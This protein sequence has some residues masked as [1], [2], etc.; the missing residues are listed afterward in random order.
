ML[1]EYGLPVGRVKSLFMFPLTFSE[2]LKALGK[3]GLAEFLNKFTLDS[4]TNFPEIIHQE[5]LS[6]L[7]L[8]F[9]LGGMPKVVS[10][11]IKTNDIT[12]AFEEQ[13]LILQGYKDDFRK[14][15]KKTDWVLLESIFTKMGQI[16]GG[17]HIKFSKIDPELKSLQIRRALTALEHAL[18]F[19][20]I[21]ATHCKKL[22][23]SAHAEEKRFKI[24]FLDI[25]LL[26]HLL[27]FDWKQIS[28]DSDLTNIADGRFAEQFVAQ[29]IVATKSNI[30]RYALH[31]WSRE[32]AGA[33]SEVDFVIE[34]N[35][36]PVPIEVKSG[37]KGKLRSLAYYIK[38]LAPEITL[39]LSQRNV[40][41]LDNMYFLPMYLVGKI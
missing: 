41:K 5:I 3:V 30:S 12:K 25:G 27:G 19:H 14:Y 31:Y 6:F 1:E 32:Q 33:E 13:A 23:L 15:A 39:V 40:Q 20:K 36:K 24:T 11:Y 4:V 26:H 21:S 16:A 2:F 7:K 38:E 8:Y 29:E 10:T 37:V 28:L 34:L 35:N 22:P 18:I 9:K 17:S